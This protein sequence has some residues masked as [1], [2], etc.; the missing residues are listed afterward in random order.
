MSKIA[1]FDK[2]DRH[3]QSGALAIFKAAL[4]RQDAPI[5]ASG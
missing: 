3:I 5:K 1:T 4:R 2:V